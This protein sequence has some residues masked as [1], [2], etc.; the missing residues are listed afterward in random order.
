M[1]RWSDYLAMLPSSNTGIK[2]PLSFQRFVLV[3]PAVVKLL[4]RLAIALSYDINPTFAHYL[5]EHP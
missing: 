1:P 5:E 4:K 2:N 3:L